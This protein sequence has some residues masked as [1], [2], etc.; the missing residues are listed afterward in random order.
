[1]KKYFLLVFAFILNNS[2]SQNDLIIK[3]ANIISMKNN[4]IEK[5]SVHIKD[6]K[7]IGIN[8]FKK[9][10]KTKKT[11]I[12][13]GENKYLTPT[14]AD[15]HVHLP[16]IKD[17]DSVFTYNLKAGV[18]KIRVMDA[19]ESNKTMHEYL[20]KSISVKPNLYLST[21]ITY[22]TKITEQNMDS[23]LL[24]NQKNNA[25]ILKIKGL[26]SEN[27]LALLLQK[28]KQYNQ[29][30]CGHFPFFVQ[31]GKAKYFSFDKV[32]NTNY[33]SIE[34]LG[35]Y[36]QM[37]NDT[38]K[39]YITITKNNGIYNC[40][41]I[42]WELV[43][44]DYLDQ[45]A[46]QQRYTYTFFKNTYGKIWDKN[47]QNYLKENG[48]A[49]AVKKA[50]ASYTSAIENKHKI[51]K[52]L[53]TNGNLLL[54]GS[55][56]SAIYQ[57]PGYNVWEEMIQWQKIGIDNFTILQAATINAASF[58]NEQNQWGT[59]EVGKNADLNIYSKN[60]L[61]DIKNI[62]TLEKVIVN[63]NILYFE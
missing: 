31:F 41:T 30:V 26:P 4:T 40:P 21:V 29:T 1:M 54:V 13:N 15:M 23:L 10:K 6:G 20:K 17:L 5:N 51:L 42:D 38:L 58:L 35:G 28:T 50:A 34:H 9:L 14:L 49:N 46:L 56:P 2:F 18:S 25:T 24:D 44:Y 52:Q 12:I 48:G 27:T 22:K 11:T 39:K 53:A 55:D 60:P 32:L 7:I 16:A 63:G 57:L 19:V 47:Y 8:N 37:D 33:K 36:D 43:A 61:D 62:T 3:N 45:T 59:I